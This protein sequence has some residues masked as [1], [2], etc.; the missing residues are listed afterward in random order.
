MNLEKQKAFIIHFAYI[1]LILGLVYVSIKFFLPLLMPFVIG[2]II[3]L[4]FRPLIDIIHD[5]TRVKRSFVS[6]FALILFYGI[7][8]LLLSMIGLKVFTYIENLFYSLPMLYEDM[9]EPAIRTIADN[10]ILHF[11]GIEIYVEEFLNNT[12]ETIFAYLKTISS[13]VVSAITGIAGQLP[14]LLI[15]L[16]F[17]I[18]SSFFFTIDY[19]RIGD[20]LMRQF[21]GNQKAMVLKLKANG[22]GTLGKFIKAYSLIIMITFFELSIG[23]WI[24]KIPNAFVLGALVAIVDILPILGTGAILLPWSIIAFI[25]GN[26]KIGIGMLLLYIVVTAVRQSIEPKIVGK[27]IGLH[28]IITLILMYVGAQL[29]GVLGLLLLPIIATIIKTLN[30]EGTINL[31]K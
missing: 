15:K 5:K 31:F 16:I 18:V 21:K 30:D 1:T 20:F 17:T 29:M 25:L 28:P 4:V 23:F 8:V 3:A 14:A 11:P 27:Q 13:N 12:S 9:I 7:L 6:I 10:L 2:M 26:F 19:Y 24:L 22:I